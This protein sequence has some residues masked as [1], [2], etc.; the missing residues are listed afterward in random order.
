VKRLAVLVALLVVAA[1]TTSPTANPTPTTAGN[2]P[3]DCIVVDVAVSSEKTAVMGQL[4]NDFN[5]DPASRVNGK[6]V[7]A[8]ML[9]KASGAAATLLSEGWPDPN[10]NGPRP[11]IWSPAARGWGA[12]VNQRLAV[13][14]Q[15]AVAPTD[16]KSFMLT[17]LT[18]A[19]P[20]P[21]A[22]ALGWPNTAIGFSDIV[23]LANDPQGWAKYGHPEWGPFKLGKTNP[24]FSTSGLNFTVAEYYAAT[25]KSSGLTREDLARPDVI[26]LVTAVEQAVV[27]YGDTT[28]TFL[29]NWFRADQRDS[30]LTYTSAVAVE[31]K[32]VIDYNLGNP[33]GELQPGEIP[34]PPKVPLV[35]IYPKEGTL[36]SD[37]PLF[38]LN[39]AWVSAD[40]RA[41]A[42][43][44]QDFV[45][46]PANQTKVLA[47]HFRPG[48]AAVPVGDPVVAANGVDPNEPQAVLDVPAPDVLTEILD[49][50]QTQRKIARVLIVM[51]ISGSMTDPAIDGRPET[52]LQLAK[53]A[54]ID[55]LDEFK[56]EDE[57]GLRVFSTDLFG[58]PG[59]NSVDLVPIGPI[60]Q[61]REGLRD[62]IRNLQ[63]QQGTPLYDA[64]GDAYT[65]M[66]GGYDARKI[67]AI[68][69]LTDGF[70][71]DG[72]RADDRAQLDALIQKL[73][74]G[75][76]GV[77]TQPV[78][79]FTIGYG[80]DA[81]LG[82]LKQISDA[83]TGA[84]YDASNPA[85]I[86]D[87]F[88]A[89]VSN[90]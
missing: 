67:N 19:M 53:Q 36:F 61:T 85:T 50:W 77:N 65:T 71:D 47:F 25:G 48:N 32:S 83:T 73:Q 52:K 24:N 28:L 86:N 6:C 8:R 12:I 81:D 63:G 23:A 66:V 62:R 60:G 59:V 35:A 4:A 29:N 10:V 7:F 69:L 70:N 76:E 64:T 54:A 27:H 22:E 51:D 16:A 89:V 17:P 55:A 45:Q 84:V 33:D 78:R 21:M 88:T 11:V 15:A 31:E 38:I 49:R 79:I 18:I 44:F 68:V 80:H 30:A 9:K 46:R 13:K 3:G 1:C 90:F 58:K 43:L 57:V 87:V 72:V 26:S 75:S 41:G 39:T 56:D 2:D 40:Q 74:A 42:V 37:N 82:V 34:R 5:N 14:G 20:K